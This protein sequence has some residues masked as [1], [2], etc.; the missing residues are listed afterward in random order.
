MFYD[1]YSDQMNDDT[2]MNQMIE[3][4][5][6]KSREIA[7]R[8]VSSILAHDSKLDLKFKE[9]LALTLAYCYFDSVSAAETISDKLDLCKLDFLAIQEEFE[10]FK[11]EYLRE[12]ELAQNF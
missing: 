7:L 8:K 2:Y 9:N 11:K 4:E 1:T 3:K 12:Y 6:Y 5:M 10:A